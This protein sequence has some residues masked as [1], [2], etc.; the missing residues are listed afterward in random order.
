MYHHLLTGHCSLNGFI[1]PDDASLSDINSS[2]EDD[3]VFY[4][5]TTN[6]LNRCVDCMKP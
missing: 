2:D 3:A 5:K 6:E 1:V 4:V